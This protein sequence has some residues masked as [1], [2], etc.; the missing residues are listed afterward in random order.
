MKKLFANFSNKMRAPSSAPDSG[1]PTTAGYKVKKRKMENLHKAA[2]MGDVS[3]LR[4]HAMCN[5]D[6]NKVDKHNR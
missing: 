1:V 5:N 6:V 3:K 4:W 2:W